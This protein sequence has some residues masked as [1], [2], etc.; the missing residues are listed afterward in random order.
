MKSGRKFAAA[1]LLAALSPLAAAQGS[2]PQADAQTRMGLRENISTLYLLRLTQALELSEDQTSRLFPVLTRIEREKAESQR[3]MNADLLALREALARPAE[4]E[5][6]LLEL[7]LRIREERRAIRQKDEETEAA[8]EKVLS[9]VQ[10]ARYL[11][12][13]VEFYRALGH[14]LERARQLKPGVKRR[15]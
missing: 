8:L 13:T 5:G 1:V 15:S 11:I 9:P 7:V 6:R 10:K 3:R 14:Q 4:D 12:F 2:G